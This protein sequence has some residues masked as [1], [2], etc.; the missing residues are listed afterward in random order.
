MVI[1]EEIWKPVPNWEGFY[2]VSNL[3]R[4]KMLSRELIYP[5]GTIHRLKEK[6]KKLT[7][8]HKNKYLMITI[9]EK[10]THRHETHCAHRIVALVHI[11]NPN[12]L[13]EVNHKKTKK[14]I[15]V[16]DLEWSSISDNKKDAYRRGLIKSKKGVE[17]HFA[18]KVGKYFNGKLIKKY[19]TMQDA[20][21]E[22][23][24][25]SAIRQAIQN[26]WNCGGFKWKYLSK[27][28]WVRRAAERLKKEVVAMKNGKIH[29]VYKNINEVVKEGHDIS[30]IYKALKNQ[31]STSGGFVWI[32]S[33]NQKTA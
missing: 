5:N 19:D 29:K 22:G 24:N 9:S 25:P 21:K 18:R 16:D 20:A 31:N 2:E 8:N 11:P 14:D 10:C 7:P 3:G 12:N 23:F 28:R 30:N 13:P 33:D 27:Q 6:I 17:T 1:R 15:T 4:F 26:N 32:Y